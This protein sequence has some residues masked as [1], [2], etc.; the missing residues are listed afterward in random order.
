MALCETTG[1][2]APWNMLQ[3][4]TDEFRLQALRIWTGLRRTISPWA[5]PTI[6]YRSRQQPI[7]APPFQFPLRRVTYA[8]SGMWLALYQRIPRKSSSHQ[9]SL[10]LLTVARK[11]HLSELRCFKS[12]CHLAST[13]CGLPF[14]V[15]PQPS[16]Y[17][18][19]QQAAQSCM[20]RFRI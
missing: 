11:L 17:W 20:C 19:P 1:K 16:D 3:C 4:Y 15:Q 9:C 5:S 7:S 2:P 14:R 10:L 12:C 18:L 8:E 6:R 13:T